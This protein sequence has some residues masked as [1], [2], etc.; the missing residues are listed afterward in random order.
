MKKNVEGRGGRVW[1]DSEGTG[2]ATFHCLWPKRIEQ[3]GPPY[4]AANG[5]EAL[6][7]LRDERVPRNRRLVLLDLNMPG[8]NGIEFLGELRGDPELRLTPVVVL[9]TSN[10]ER[11]KV[12]AYGFNVA[13]Y[14]VKPVTFPS[15]MELAAALDKYW[16][17]VEMP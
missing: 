17:L 4:V 3:E 10:D 11:D 13:G 2:G 9:T 6:A 15:F 5:I 16:A 8:M 1:I 7:M 14:L 12:N